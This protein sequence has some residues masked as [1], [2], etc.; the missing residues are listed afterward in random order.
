[1]A[2][3]VS[4]RGQPGRPPSPECLVTLEQMEIGGADQWVLERSEDLNNPIVLFVHGG[5]GTSQLTSNR[6]NTRD[7]ERC[8]TVVNWDQR[9]AGKS[10]AAIRETAA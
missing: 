9:G 3:H 1:M 5:S 8:F 2:T 4:S 10:Y 7:L 6:L